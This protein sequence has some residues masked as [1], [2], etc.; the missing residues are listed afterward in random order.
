M[1]TIFVTLS[2]VVTVACAEPPTSKLTAEQ[3][4]LLK[5][6]AEQIN[7]AERFL[8][9]R[10]YA[11]ATKPAAKGVDITL[12]ARGLEHPSSLDVLTWGASVK[13]MN[14]DFMGAAVDW[15]TVVSLRVKLLGS[16]HW[17]TFDA[18]HRLKLAE[19]AKVFPEEQQKKLVVAI[20]AES[21]AKTLWAIKPS[22]ALEFANEAMTG[23]GETL[24]EQ[25]VEV[26]RVR[27]LIGR[28]VLGKNDGK[29]AK[30][31]N[32]TVLAIRQKLLPEN[33][34]DI[35]SS[36]HNLG[37]A[38]FNLGAKQDAVISYQE[39]I[40]IWK[41]SL[42]VSDI[43]VALGLSNLGN[44]Q[45]ELREYVP[46]KASYT[47]ALAIRR[48]ALKENDPD[49]ANCLHNLANVQRE[50]REY[51]AAKASYMEALSIYRKA[52]PENDPN[53]ANSLHDLGVVQAALKEYEAAKASLTEA[54]SI[55]RKAL[56]ENDPY[57]AN[58]L[59][60]LGVVQVDLR[61]YKAAKA[62]LTEA[63]A[64]RRKTLKKND[65]NIANSLF[66]L[67][68]VQK[69]LREHEAAKASF[70]EA[71]A[72]R[73]KVLPE[74]DPQIADCLHNLGVVQVDLREYEAAKA[75]FTESLAIRRK[76]L[77]ENDPAIVHSLNNL[78]AMQAMLR[79]YELAKACFTEALAIRR[80]ALK[81]NDPQI[82][83]C[84]HNLGVVQRELREYEAAKANLTEAL[85]ICRKAL[86][87]N[88][89][90]IANSLNSLG[91]VQRDLREYEAAKASF[92]EA[93][94]IRRKA[95]PENDPNIAN[96][97]NSL[98][99]VQEALQEHKAAK[100]SLTEA[101]A[102]YR[103]AVPKNDTDI[104]KSLMNLGVAQGSL[105]EYEAAKASFTEALAI[106]R[107]GLPKDHP[108][109]AGSLLFLSLHG[110]VTRGLEND[111]RGMLLEAMTIKRLECIRL[112]AIQAEGEQLRTAAQG[113]DT[114]SLS[115]S[116]TCDRPVATADNYH[117]LAA[118]KGGVTALQR[119]AQ[120]ARD[121]KDKTT[122]D[123]LNQLVV[124]DRQMLS[125]ALPDFTVNKSPV[126]AIDF[127]KKHW[128]LSERR[129]EL[130]RQLAAQSKAYRAYQ[131]KAKL[132]GNDVRAALASQPVANV[133]IDFRE[134]THYGP[135]PKAPADPIIEPRFMA[136]VVHPGKDGLVAQISLGKA[137]V[138]NQWVERW[139]ASYGVGKL[140]DRGQPDPGVELRKL[141]WEPLVKHLPKDVKTVLI[142]PDGSLTRI[143]FASLPGS[144]QGS[145]LLEKYTFVTM[146]VPI[147][148]PDLIAPKKPNE[149]RSLLAMGGIDYGKTIEQGGF[150]PLAKTGLEVDA[151]KERF[152]KRFPTGTPHVVKAGQATKAEFVAQAANATHLHLATHAYF[153]DES[154]KSATDARDLTLVDLLNFDRRVTGT[155]PDLLSGVVFAGVNNV[156]AAGLLTAK[157]VSQL[158][159]P[160]AE[161]VVL[162]ACKTGLGKV[163]GGEGVLG[164]Q[165]AFHVA[166]AK[167]VL[168]TLWSADDDATQKLMEQ[169]YDNLWIEKLP[170]AEAL[171][172]A[173]RWMIKNYQP[174][175]EG[176]MKLNGVLR[177]PP[178]LGAGKPIP[179]GPV[180]V[181]ERTGQLPPYFWAGF[182]LSGDWR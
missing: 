125:T 104:A 78:G 92:T 88:D 143:P 65:P 49:I 18:K 155:N 163:A 97:L 130:E 173:Q 62:N 135:G 174:T 51:E 24:G 93:L 16:D 33:H 156:R 28:I 144:T 57:I 107:R 77:P 75:N 79:E 81:V 137:E 86:P 74:N 126:L 68:G 140:P 89:P 91:G 177:G 110:L 42:G 69:H 54:L 1:R 56:P 106:Q 66:G 132:G 160:K 95:L 45:Y 164:L 46:A 64:I 99:V 118:W 5:E 94:A 20:T 53:I 14:R 181:A 70:I 117:C 3:V 38:Q 150:P 162:S 30:E 55:Y 170:A 166:G 179:V 142:S 136:F 101:L 26:A 60:N 8:A 172:E 176:W 127:Q 52:L 58:S 34:P 80:K 2:F 131:E 123:L 124:L 114:Q 87:E 6:A 73:R 147:L 31:A 67:G 129:K 119:W 27:H 148:I 61:E 146:P 167:R 178:G 47:E 115:L 120:E 112:A 165:R 10:K 154:V 109:L 161:L 15:K 102:I 111:N 32:D 133:L 128:E 168:S 108:D 41:T 13:E 84:L 90:D 48:K 180:P 72:I 9:E 158:N 169:F 141:V 171:R 36:I 113:R 39:A 37:L 139:R 182:V 159:L 23:Y 103:K 149:E 63:L 7:I 157:E 153:A 71:L 134:Y 17:M 12:K 105:L 19:Q 85:A 83:D 151:L 35:G 121:T 40:R 98:G 59:H 152:T 4:A 82:A 145:F 11:D 50:H 76:A 96:S 29:G 175:E 44:A 25:T 22:G 138:I 43:Q 21:Q 122:A 116:E 100:A